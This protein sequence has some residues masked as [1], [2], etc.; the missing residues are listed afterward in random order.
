MFRREEPGPLSEAGAEYFDAACAA[1]GEPAGPLVD[2]I[3]RWAREI[4]TELGADANARQLLPGRC[5]G[6]VEWTAR[7]CRGFLANALL[8]NLADT[9]LAHDGTHV[10]R[11][12]L[13]FTRM[14]S[15]AK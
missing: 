3:T 2:D 5:S 4:I 11:G 12:G 15:N 7:Q 9:A 8:G 1:I 13:N 14:G 10:Q 6:S